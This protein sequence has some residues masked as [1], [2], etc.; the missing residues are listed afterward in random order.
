MT[1]MADQIVSLER[2]YDALIKIDSTLQRKLRS[3]RINDF[4]I[5]KVNLGLNPRKIF[6]GDKEWVNI[7]TCLNRIV[8]TNIMLY[9]PGIPIKAI[10]ESI[11]ENDINFIK[12]YKEKLQG[13]KLSDEKILIEV[14]R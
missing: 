4:I 9:P 14:I 7:E 1:T 11:K 2:L 13:I 5:E 8:A 10:G 12:E 6:Y 3:K